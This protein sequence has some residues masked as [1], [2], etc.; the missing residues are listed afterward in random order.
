MKTV[1]IR[2]SAPAYKWLLNQS[3]LNKEDDVNISIVVD[4]LISEY[5]SDFK[6]HNYR[7]LEKELVDKK[8]ELEQED[9]RIRQE[10]KNIGEKLKIMRDQSDD[11]FEEIGEESQQVTEKEQM[12]KTALF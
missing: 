8:T 9:K 11:L 10:L 4:A 2:I 5:D 7:E 12:L 6:Q 3:K 1:T